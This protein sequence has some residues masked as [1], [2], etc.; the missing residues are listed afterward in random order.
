MRYVGEKWRR[1]ISTTVLGCY[2][3]TYVYT[4]RVSFGGWGVGGH[5]APLE[6]YVPPLGICAS[7]VHTTWRPP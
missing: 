5:L 7:H 4:R 6:S 2:V 3:C 1:I